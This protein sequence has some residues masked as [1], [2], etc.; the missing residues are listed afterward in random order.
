[1]PKFDLPRAQ[2]LDI[3]AFLHEG[4]RAAA[5]RGTYKVLNIVT[6]D[7]KA[8]EAYFNGAGK[9]STCHSICRRFE[10]RRGEVRSRHAAG[11]IPDAR[12]KR[13]AAPHSADLR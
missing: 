8:G 7:A 9:C 6:G 13:R 12:G 4:V 2:I 1:M 5:E 3:A 10:R 11:K